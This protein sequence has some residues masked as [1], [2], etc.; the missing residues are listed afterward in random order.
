MDL[1]D[2]ARTNI[3]EDLHLPLLCFISRKIVNRKLSCVTKE[4]ASYH[5]LCPIS[6]YY[7]L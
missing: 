5:F 6:Y 1:F 7:S 2:I 4:S 3:A